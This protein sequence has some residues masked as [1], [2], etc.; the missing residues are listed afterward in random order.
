MAVS[1]RKAAAIA[2]IFLL[3]GLFG[4]ILVAL[5]SGVSLAMQLDDGGRE[6]HGWYLVE[7]Y[8]RHLGPHPLASDLP[9]FEKAGAQCN[10]AEFDNLLLSDENTP[11]PS[12]SKY[13]GY[14]LV[15]YAGPAHLREGLDFKTR[16][17]FVE[18]HLSRF[19]IGFL[20]ECLDS[21]FASPLCASYFER[22][23]RDEG[24]KYSLRENDFDDAERKKLVELTENAACAYLR[25]LTPSLKD[26]PQ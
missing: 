25:G 10:E 16:R 5:W 19:E 12:W 21:T 23:I 14:A 2:G 3:G 18:A 4:P 22:R 1:I 7:S 26:A 8:R 20:T 11:L 9:T 15:A 6:P 24:F 17:D 13:N